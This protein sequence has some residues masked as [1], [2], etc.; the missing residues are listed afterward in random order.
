M[1]LHEAVCRPANDRVFKVPHV[2]AFIVREDPQ[3]EHPRRVYVSDV[4]GLE[5]EEAQV[6]SRSQREEVPE[7]VACGD[8][9][10]VHVP[11]TVLI[12]AT[13]VPHVSLTIYAVAITS[14]AVND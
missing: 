5:N 12:G 14:V 4:Q 6:E 1:F 7:C 8:R 11:G 10:V 9:C 3:D 2:G 13:L